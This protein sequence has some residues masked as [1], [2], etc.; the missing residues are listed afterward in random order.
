M[1]NFIYAIST[2]KDVLS[3]NDHESLNGAV[4]D[5]I[6]QELSI[7]EEIEDNGYTEEEFEKFY[8]DLL[9]LNVTLLPTS[10]KAI[11]KFGE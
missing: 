1:K 5:R 6:E 4:L 10:E 3:Y 7:L 8:K 2:I 11:K 9:N